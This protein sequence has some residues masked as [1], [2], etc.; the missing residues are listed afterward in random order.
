M[1]G[2][3]FTVAGGGMQDEDLGQRRWGLRGWRRGCWIGIRG[4]GI[5]RMSIDVEGFSCHIL[6]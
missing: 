5:S 6:I 3:D 1:G 2:T 4:I